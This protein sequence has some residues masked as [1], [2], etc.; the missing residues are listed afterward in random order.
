MFVVFGDLGQFYMLE[1]DSFRD[2]AHKPVAAL[3]SLAP[4]SLG[5][6]WYR[7]LSRA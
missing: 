3:D 4:V 7:T 5:S 6:R 2:I 1:C